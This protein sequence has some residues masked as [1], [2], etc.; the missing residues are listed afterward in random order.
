MDIEFEFSGG[1]ANVNLAYHGDTD[2]LPPEIASKLLRLIESSG[3]L[4]LQQ[5]EIASTNTGPPDVFYY[6][7]MLYDGNKKKS[8]FFNDVTAPK[9]LRPLLDFLQELAWEQARQNR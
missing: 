7:L 6:K 8:F 9:E 2:K 1:Y 3:V 5:S 4:E